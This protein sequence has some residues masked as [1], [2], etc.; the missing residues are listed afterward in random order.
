MEALLTQQKELIK[1]LNAHLSNLKKLN[2]PSRTQE[3]LN[4]KQA[5]FDADWEKFNANHIRILSM[6]TE[7][8]KNQPYIKE[9][10]HEAVNTCA[11]EFE[12][13]NNSIPKGNRRKG[14]GT[15]AKTGTSRQNSE[16]KKT[17]ALRV[18]QRIARQRHH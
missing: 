11:A 17:N 13:N 15:Q 12:K 16:N 4:R 6:D 2:N 9:K 1:S 10:K 14:N 8:T 3:T 18:Y 5:E 7:L